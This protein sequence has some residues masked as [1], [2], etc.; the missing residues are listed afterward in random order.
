[1]YAS[2]GDSLVTPGRQAG[3]DMQIFEIIEVLGD[4]GSPPYRVRAA[5]GHESVVYPGPDT[6]VQH[7]S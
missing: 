7:K 4:N 1:M 2:L 5:N 3:Q 6:T